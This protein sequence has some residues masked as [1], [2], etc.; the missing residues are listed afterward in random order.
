MFLRD[1]LKFRAPG[2]CREFHQNESKNVLA[3]VIVIWFVYPDRNFHSG[4]EGKPIL[5]AT[6][7]ARTF[8]F[9]TWTLCWLPSS[10]LEAGLG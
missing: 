9:R 5:L 4:F 6:V 10:L 3:L 2:R 7:K 1:V 8:G